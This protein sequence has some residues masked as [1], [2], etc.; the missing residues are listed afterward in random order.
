MKRMILF[1]AL[2]VSLCAG[3][4]QQKVILPGKGKIDVERLNKQIPT[5]IDVSQ[6]SIS[7]V[8]VLRNAFAARQG[9]CF[10]SGDLRSIFDATLWYVHVMSDLVWNE[11]D[12]Q[13]KPIT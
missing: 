1:V 9:Y 10:T 2:A 12:V 4:Q 5:N 8:R 6:L 3:A 13:A 7:E 11:D